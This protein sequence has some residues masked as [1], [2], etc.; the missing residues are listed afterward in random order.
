MLTWTDQPYAAMWTHLRFLSHERNARRLLQNDLGASRILTSNPELLEAKATQLSYCIVQAYEYYQA[1]ESVTINT[2]P[3]LYFY[4]MLSLAKGLIVAHH[5]SKLLNDVKYHGL[6]HD[7][8]ARAST[9]DEQVAILAGGV[10]DDFTQVAAGVNFPKGAAFVLKDVLSISPELS[11]MYERYYSDKA[12]SLYLYGID[13]LS[14]NPYQVRVCPQVQTKEEAFARIPEL[15][16]RLRCAGRE[17]PWS[18]DCA[19]FETYHR[20]TSGLSSRVW[21]SSGRQIPRG[22]ASLY[23]RRC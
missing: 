18:S 4:G 20:E 5:P 14:A 16:D 1:A 13:V 15:G 7:K 3:L 22:S 19:G 12:R 10:F 6:H 23:S 8:A 11:N 17:I 21:T 2:S 9:L